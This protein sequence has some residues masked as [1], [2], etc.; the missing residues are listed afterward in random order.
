MF[1]GAHFHLLLNHL[2]IIVPAIAL[3]VL[4]VGLWKDDDKV[5]RTGLAILVV[6]ALS[7]LPAYLTGEP[8]E[9]TVE[10]LPGVTE[11]LIERHEDAA[12]IGAILL[13]VL[14]V[15]ALV[16][17]WRYRGLA[18]VPRRAVLGVTAGTVVAAALMGW[19]GLLGG[20]I[21]HTEVRP[22]AAAGAP[23]GD[24]TYRSAEADEVEHDARR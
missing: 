13:G 3:A 4:A 8:A 15:A 24:S 11:R 1:G 21:R 17:L 20:E 5:A 14:G 6:G 16:A 23:A 12:L 22:A 7:A 10:R 19:V 9:D 2:P 18:R